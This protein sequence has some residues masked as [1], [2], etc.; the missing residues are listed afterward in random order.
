MEKV[1]GYETP[2]WA[3]ACF[4]LAVV[5][6]G[7]A[8]VMVIA[9]LMALEFGIIGSSQAWMFAGAVVALLLWAILVGGLGALLVEVRKHRISW[10]QKNE[11]DS[12]VEGEA[13]D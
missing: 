13:K 11:I 1:K 7:A 5:A 9:A 4:G 8:L 2:I 3:Q 10:C 6:G 12:D